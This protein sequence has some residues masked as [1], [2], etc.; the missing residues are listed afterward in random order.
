MAEIWFRQ[1]THIIVSVVENDH[2]EYI[3]ILKRIVCQRR[4][5]D[6]T[7]QDKMTIIFAATDLKPS[8]LIGLV[9]MQDTLT[10]C[11]IEGLKLLIFSLIIF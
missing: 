6:V 4:D 3:Q 7:N 8:S 1:F 10:G 9:N 2:I 11:L 5:Y